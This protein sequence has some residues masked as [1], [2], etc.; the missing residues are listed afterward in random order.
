MKVFITA[1]ANISK[2]MQW[3]AGVTMC[4]IMAITLADVIMRPF[5]YPI[6]GAFEVIS[7]LGAIVVGFAVPYTSLMNG[8]IYVDF[9]INSFS[10]NHK[11]VLHATTRI[12]GIFLFFI[13]GWFFFSMAKDLYMKGEVST[14]LKLPFYP[15]AAG[16]GVSCF[17]QVFVLMCN[18]IKTYG[19]A[20]E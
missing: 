20:H 14:T 3:V 18:I 5:G 2:G 16:L 17:V 19:D 8:H 15:I 10:G 12:M 13:L 1:L 7:F 11:N 9:L 4:V 6:I